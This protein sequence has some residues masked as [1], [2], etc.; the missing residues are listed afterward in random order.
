MSII[1]STRGFTFKKDLVEK[2]GFDYKNA[3]TLKD[4]EPF[5]E[6]VKSGES[7]MYG[8]QVKDGDYYYDIE[9]KTVSF[10]NFLYYDENADSIVTY[11]SFDGQLDYFKTLRS[12]YEKG[13]IAKDAAVRKDAEADR[14]SG[15]FAVFYNPSVLDDGVKSS[16]TYGFPCA[17]SEITTTLVG[18]GSVQG[19]CTGISVTSENPERAMMLADILYADR[20]FFNLVCYGI[21]GQDFKVVSGAGTDE[22]TIE[23][24]KDLTWAVWSP[25]IGSLYNEYPNN[26][27]TAAAL[28]GIRKANESAKVSKIMGFMFDQEP[29]KNEVAQC[30]AIRDEADKIL[31]TGTTPDPEKYI[32][33]MQKKMEN[34]GLAKVKAEIEKQLADWKKAN[35]K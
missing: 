25:W 26:N 35:G 33:E 1:A 24:N 10:T 5:L 13:Y 19:A 31:A 7:G 2:Y 15:K 23:T 17:D 22:P 29:V 20:K 12:F 18:T 28:A 9:S 8:L 6:K 4:I 32:S 11:G 30:Q 16:A 3:H 34:A 14:K 27:N 21:E